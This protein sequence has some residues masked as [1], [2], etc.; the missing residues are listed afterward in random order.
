MHVED[1]QII[2]KAIE[3]EDPLDPETN[4]PPPRVVGF[5]NI[6]L[7]IGVDLAYTIRMIE[8]S[9]NV[10]LLVKRQ[11]KTIPYGHGKGRQEIQ[12]PSALLSGRVQDEP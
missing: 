5:A 7:D 2:E 10:V 9:A 11:G 8:S 4:P 3:A 12:G 6:E 1:R